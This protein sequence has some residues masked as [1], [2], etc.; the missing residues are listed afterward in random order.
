MQML[1]ALHKCMELKWPLAPLRP[2]AGLYNP[3][4]L[5][6]HRDPYPHLD[7]LRVEAP[8]YY[9]RPLGS[10]LVS[11]YDRAQAV[12]SDQR[13][14]SDRKQDRSFRNRMTY[15]ML[16]F[17]P[18]EAA[19]LDASLVS[20][21]PEIHQRM[22]SAIRADFSRS[23]IEQLQPRMEA[24]VDLLLDKAEARGQIDLIA[25]FAGPLPVLVAAELL[26]LPPRDAHRIQEWSDSFIVLVD[27]L[28]RG[29]GTVRWRRAF[30]EFDAYL[31]DAIEEKRRDPGDDLLTRLLACSDA[32]EL[33]DLQVRT[34]TLMLLT[35][36][37]EVVTNLIGNAVMCLLRNPDERER[38]Q[39]DPNLWGSAIEEVIRLESPIQS[40]WRIATEEIQVGE[41]TVP[42][43]RAVTVLIGAA[44][45][46][47]AHFAEPHRFDVG[48]SENRH[49][50]FAMGAHYCAGPWLARIEGATALRRLTTRFPGLDGDPTTVRWKPVTGLRGVYAL[51]VTL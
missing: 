9:S 45:R 31:V 36:G 42:A 48:R 33:D 27:P 35:A 47:P 17:T 20:V 24:W 19:A 41:R 22:R 5:D 50:G 2:M 43:G 29:A 12:L 18:K 1:G 25:D 16:K 8:V 10:F 15:R 26:G 46:D 6:F 30:V 34:L 7:R 4:D 13:F 37:H 39:T 11:S 32:G 21:P 44:N 3:F 28:I 14:V 51:P 38:L 23:R 49:L 40:A